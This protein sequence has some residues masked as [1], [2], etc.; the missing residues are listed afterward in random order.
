VA[1]GPVQLR[2]LGFDEPNFHGEV[3]RK[4]EKLRETDAVRVIDALAVHEDA[5][6]RSRSST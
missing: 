2:V 3:T 4:L 6:A 5:Q 1:V